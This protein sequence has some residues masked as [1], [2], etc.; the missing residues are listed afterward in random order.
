MKKILL[1]CKDVVY[2]I[3]CRH[4]G[5]IFRYTADEIT[6]NDRT[7]TTY[8]NCYIQCPCCEH[9]NAHNRDA[10]ITHNMPKAPYVPYTLKSCVPSHLCFYCGMCPFGSFYKADK[11]DKKTLRQYNKVIK[12]F[13]RQLRKAC[14]TRFIELANNTASECSENKSFSDRIESISKKWGLLI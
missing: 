6:Y 4:C 7:Y 10:D 2:E 9:M 13:K 3:T 11:S 14:I 5:A 8:V 1:D 12:S